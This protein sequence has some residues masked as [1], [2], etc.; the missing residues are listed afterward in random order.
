MGLELCIKFST[1]SYI[2]RAVL[3]FEHV[4]EGYHRHSIICMLATVIK[5]YDRQS[6][7]LPSF[8]QIHGADFAQKQASA[9]PGVH[10]LSH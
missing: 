5:S 7:L 4:P 1:S 3:V 9:A 8:V 6:L 10:E 2:S